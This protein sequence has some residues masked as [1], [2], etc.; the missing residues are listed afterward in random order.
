MN[1]DLPDLSP[2]ETQIVMVD[3]VGIRSAEEM[4]DGCEA[5]IPGAKIPSDW[6]LDRLTGNS[7][8]DTEYIL[9]S[10]AKCPKCGRD[11][12]EKTLIE[13]IRPR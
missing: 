11:V 5:C 4:I 2:E 8:V 1:R 12:T 10:P 3:S 7:G 13:W 9:E 6:L